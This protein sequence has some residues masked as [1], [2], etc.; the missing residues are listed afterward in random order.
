MINYVGTP[1]PVCKQKFTEDEPRPVVCPD[2]GAPYHRACYTEEGECIF[3][4]KHKDGY[5]WSIG[6]EEI[7]EILN[8]PPEEEQTPAPAKQPETVKEVVREVKDT[9][10]RMFEDIRPAE[11]DESLIFGVSEK[12]ISCFMGGGISPMRFMKYRQI[13]AGRKVGFNILAGIFSP[14]YM[15]FLRM[16][17]PGIMFA[18]IDFL[19]GLPGSRFDLYEVLA[20]GEMPPALMILGYISFGLRIVFAMFFDYF[21]LRWSAYRIRMT[22]VNYIHETVPD[23]TPDMTFKLSDLSDDYFRR[24]KNMGRP[25]M[26][27]MLLDSIAVHFVSRLIITIF[28]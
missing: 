24:L 27:T 6:L 19:L 8:Q 5:T 26:R 11:G 15:F 2:C 23:V 9:F 13:A 25:S 18:L 22:R 7:R 1:C 14:Y 17:G 4:D 28:M 3:T 12:E 10:E 21:Y 16:R 20:T